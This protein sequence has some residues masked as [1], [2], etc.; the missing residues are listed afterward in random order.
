MVTTRHAGAKMKRWTL[1]ELR[2]QHLLRAPPR[3]SPTVPLEQR[4]KDELFAPIWYRNIGH[5]YGR[6]SSKYKL[7][8]SQPWFDDLL[9]CASGAQ[10][11]HD[12]LRACAEFGQR[13]RSLNCK[14]A[15]RGEALELEIAVWARAQTDGDLANSLAMLL[16]A[17]LACR[18]K[19][20]L[21]RD[22]VSSLPFFVRVVQEFVR[23]GLFSQ[24]ETT[25]ELR[26][27]E[28]LRRF[29]ALG[30]GS[31]KRNPTLGD[32][33]G[34]FMDCPVALALPAAEN[35]AKCGYGVTRGKEVVNRCD[36]PWVRAEYGTASRAAM[37]DALRAFPEYRIK[38]H[39]VDINWVWWKRMRDVL[40]RV[41]AG[42]LD[43]L[44]VQVIRPTDGTP[45][46][47]T[48]Y[49][50][51]AEIRA[52]R[53]ARGDPEQLA[54]LSREPTARRLVALATLLAAGRSAEHGLRVGT[55][56]PRW[57]PHVYNLYSIFS[58]EITMSD[59]EY[60]SPN[61]SIFLS[62][63]V[64]FLAVHSDRTEILAHKGAVPAVNEQNV[65]DARNARDEA[66]T[67][68][69]NLPASYVTKLRDADAERDAKLRAPVPQTKEE[70]IIARGDV[71][72]LRAQ[73]KARGL[74]TA[75][76][77]ADLEAR[78]ANP[79]PE[80]R[81]DYRAPSDGRTNKDPAMRLRADA[82]PIAAAAGASRGASTL[83]T[84]PPSLDSITMLPKP[85][86]ES[87]VNFE[88]PRPG[89]PS[90][91]CVM[92]GKEGM[93]PKEASETSANVVVIPKQNKSVCGGCSKA[94]WLATNGCYFKYC[95][96]HKTFCEIHAFEGRLHAAKCNKAAAAANKS[97]RKRAAADKAASKPAK[98]SKDE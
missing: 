24:D 75:G 8:P 16:G 29:V 37:L 83:V 15:S 36:W 98:K 84:P 57:V 49:F 47:E 82:A 78:L 18:N 40:E 35:S 51:R 67:E 34:F 41:E 20:D 55:E 93:D 1:A 96:G 58:S 92:C 25:F 46:D 66:V 81:A 13:V 56:Q 68:E 94:W 23:F 76:N 39:I 12:A 50:P 3:G 44:T 45:V 38:R 72:A 79:Q 88:R 59:K 10:N 77:K 7:D 28:K 85:P 91:H 61:G 9:L 95:Q 80:D 27:G 86:Y 73:C 30:R 48:F 63:G 32:L 64:R 90:A 17:Y 53:A 62:I 89:H 11:L 97:D 42:A 21:R 31:R 74:K 54:A 43:G 60:A 4:V 14:A 33:S 26:Y 52:I 65:V 6:S 22:D 19:I 5:N 70:A 2:P 69:T 87:V 71:R